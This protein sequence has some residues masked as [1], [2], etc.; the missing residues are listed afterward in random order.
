MDLFL[1]PYAV[2]EHCSGG[3]SEPG[4]Q[5]PVGKQP[6]PVAGYL[7]GAVFPLIFG[8]IGIK[9]LG[10]GVAVV[11]YIEEQRPCIHPTG[12]VAVCIQAFVG[13]QQ[14]SLPDA[15]VLKDDVDG[16]TVGETDG[17]FAGKDFLNGIVGAVSEA[18]GAAVDNVDPRRHA[19]LIGLGHH[20][21]GER[22]HTGGR[23]DG[24]DLCG[25]VGGQVVLAFQN[26]LHPPGDG[27]DLTGHAVFDHLHG[28]L[29]VVGL[30]VQIAELLGQAEQCDDD[31]QTGG[32]C[33]H[34]GPAAAFGFG[35]RLR[36]WLRGQI[37]IHDLFHHLKLCFGQLITARSIFGFRGSFFHAQQP[38]HRNAEN[39][40][41]GDQLF[42]LGQSGV[43]LPFVNGLTGH[44]QLFAQ[45]LLRQSQFL[46]LL[47][48]SLS[49]GHGTH[50][51]SP[52]T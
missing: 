5:I 28:G 27:A 15:A 6:H 22:D 1:R 8:Q 34:P 12:G 41:Q 38:A 18:C 44:A 7:S 17:E 25:I 13:V 33:N 35:S 23:V 31:G 46:S 52:S 39:T 16:G 45:G 20:P 51:L 40:A 26:F 37:A 10:Q 49:N 14:L 9:I 4:H 19:R 32:G 43:R 11:I 47:C 29:E 3:R 24:Y 21:V 30:V 42:D 36:L 48:D 50:F 2:E